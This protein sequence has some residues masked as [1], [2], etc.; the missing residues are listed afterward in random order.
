MSKIIEILTIPIM[1]MNGFSAIAG[2]AWL[3]LIGEWK[4]LGIGIALLFTSHFILSL[5]CYLAC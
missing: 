2:G 3:V 4:L 1:L 5:Q